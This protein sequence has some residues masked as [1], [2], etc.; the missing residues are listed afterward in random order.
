MKCKGHG[1]D[2][3]EID[4]IQNIIE[5]YQHKFLE[6]IFTPNE[7]AYCQKKSHPFSHFA[8]RFAAKEAVVKALGV[9]FGK[10]IA[11]LDIEIISSALGKPEVILSE[12]ANKIFSF[13][14]L[15]LSMSHCKNYATSSVIYLNDQD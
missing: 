4:R 14:R 11:F 7:I 15:L 13:P 12:R 2:I 10:H 6:R 1:I 5:K 8:V 9:G 3:I